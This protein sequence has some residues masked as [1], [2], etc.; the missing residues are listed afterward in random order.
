MGDAGKEGGEPHPPKS[1]PTP[2]EGAAQGK[3]QRILLG[4]QV[5][6]LD[7]LEVD[8][9]EGHEDEEGYTKKEVRTEENEEGYAK[10]EV[11][12]GTVKARA[13]GREVGETESGS[14]GGWAQ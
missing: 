1:A 11:R 2:R 14:R 9:V 10:K 4:G 5:A 8:A 3:Q 7:E 13:W 12:K 6:E